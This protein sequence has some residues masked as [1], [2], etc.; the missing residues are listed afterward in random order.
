MRFATLSDQYMEAIPKGVTTIFYPLPYCASD[1]IVQQLSEFVD[2]G[3]QLYISGDLSYDSS[4][5]R[6]QTERLKTLCGLEFVSERFPNIAYQHGAVETVPNDPGW[7]KY[8]ASPGI[9]TRLAGAQLLLAGKDGTP[10]VTEFKRGQGRVIFSSDPI[11]LHGDPRY[12]EYADRKSV[13]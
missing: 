12:Q 2:K 3:G 9:V 4:R 5:Q 10:I 11:E 13:V 1:A 8:I 6:T 7:P